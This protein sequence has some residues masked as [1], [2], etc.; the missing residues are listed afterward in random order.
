MNAVG[1]GI[2]IAWLLITIGL[3]LLEAHAHFVNK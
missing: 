2:A 1:I 3:V